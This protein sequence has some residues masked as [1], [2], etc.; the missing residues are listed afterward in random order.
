MD[1]LLVLGAKLFGLA[2]FKWVFIILLV[3]DIIL[4]LIIN[5]VMG[6]IGVVI[7]VIILVVFLI[8]GVPI[9]PILITFLVICIVNNIIF[10]S[11]GE[12]N[13]LQIIYLITSIIGMILYFIIL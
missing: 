7:D 10:F 8:L 1:L 13:P 12:P 9:L 6:I 5:G 4:G 2:A 3:V 11:I